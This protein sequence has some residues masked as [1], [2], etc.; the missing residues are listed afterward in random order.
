MGS[1]A[2]LSSVL[3]QKGA[4]TQVANDIHG[5]ILVLP[6]YHSRNHNEGVIKWPGRGDEY[7]WSSA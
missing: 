7:V 3:V 2:L 1:L 5:V 4:G 6:L